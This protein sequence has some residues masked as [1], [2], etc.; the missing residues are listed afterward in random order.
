MATNCL[1]PFLLNQLLEPILARTALAEQTP[2]HVRVVWVA[3]MITASVPDGGI[4]FDKSGSPK[5]LKNAMQNYMQTKVG[6]VF[7]ASEAAKRLRKDGIISMVGFRPLESPY[8]LWQSLTS[9]QSVN[10]GLM[11]TELQRHS[12]KIQSVIMVCLPH[13]T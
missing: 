4:Q 13:P 11:K 9:R 7:L 5:V 3:S 12:P 10:P 1:G 8:V 6:N 2:D